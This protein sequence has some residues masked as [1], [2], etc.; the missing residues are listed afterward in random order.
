M[1]N[2][3]YSSGNPALGVGPGNNCTIVDELCDIKD[4]V[5]SIIHSKVFDYGVIC[6]SEQSAVVV[7]SVYE[8]FKKEM[9]YRGCYFMNIE[10]TEKVGQFILPINPAGVC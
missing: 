1:V 2:A 3:A 10:E 7:D 6:A 8:E 5:S 9:A 4:A